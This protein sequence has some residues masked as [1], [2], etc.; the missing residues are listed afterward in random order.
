MQL[1][2]TSL[3]LKKIVEKDECKGEGEG[4]KDVACDVS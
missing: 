3:L 1:C 4:E 2:V